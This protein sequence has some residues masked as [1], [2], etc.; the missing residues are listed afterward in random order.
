M[1][2]ENFS[3]LMLCACLHIFSWTSKD[4][5]SLMDESGLY[6]SMLLDL[7]AF[8]PLWQSQWITKAQTVAND[9]LKSYGSQLH[10]LA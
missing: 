2:A 3:C 6:L 9:C 7:Q 1:Q 8:C 10:R 5:I 4:R